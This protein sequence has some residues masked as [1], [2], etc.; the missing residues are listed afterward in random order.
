MP[1]SPETMYRR[2][3]QPLYDTFTAEHSKFGPQTTFQVFLDGW[4]SEINKA[5]ASCRSCIGVCITFLQP[6]FTRTT[7]CLGIREL[8]GKHT[9]EAISTLVQGMLHEHGIPL[10][11]V[12]DVATDNAS[13]EVAAALDLQEAA[14]A[15]SG[16]TI[17]HTRCFAHTLNLAVREGLAVSLE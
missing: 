6:D 13:T 3:F 4:S 12:I 15:L 11:N 2:H 5:S 8:P 17:H 10:T 16:S 9:A 7:R 1:C 14:T